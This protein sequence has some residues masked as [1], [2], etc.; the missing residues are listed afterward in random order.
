MTIRSDLSID[1][2]VSPRIITVAAPSTEITMQDLLDTLRD[3]EAKPANV[4]DNYIVDAAGK[5][6]LGG[7]VR[8]GLTVTL[9]NA[10]LAFEARSG[11]DYV[12]C[13]ITGGNLVAVD[14]SGA[15]ISPIHPT[16]YTQIVL[17]NSSSATLQEQ[18]S[19]QYSSFNGGVTYDKTSPYSG[20]DFPTGTPQQPV[21]NVYD[22]YDIAIKYG[23]TT[24]YVISDLT[25]P[26][27][28]PL[29]GFTFIG[30]GK[31]RTEII[32]PDAASVSGC[33]YIDAHIT[34]YLDGNNTLKDCLVDD[35]HYIKGYLEQCVLAPGTI[36]LAGS[37]EAHFLDCYSGVP[38][39]GTPTI[40]MGTSGQALA[41]RNYNGGIKLINKA[42]PEP[43]SIDLNSGQIKLDSTVTGGDIVCRGVGK[44]IDA[45]TDEPI[46]TGDWYGANIINEI[47][48]IHN[49]ADG[50]WNSTL[51]HHTSAG[52]TG[53]A[54]DKINKNTKL[55]PATV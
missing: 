29:E 46:H 51:S 37:E 18:T 4:D 53:E 12:Q 16:A 10:Q 30:A 49:V 20:T 15:D 25:L 40:D 3:E 44:L 17:A 9:Q 21:N 11:P 55:I 47:I 6:N 35:L 26:T 38:G 13:N 43:V 2:E 27:D 28:L 50:V 33:S 1:W 54:L 7:G 34:G 32:I 19:I 41:L 14:A 48:S 31:D 24:G 39:T 8:V 23:F 22:A 45:D 52:S 42:G 36:V 5:E